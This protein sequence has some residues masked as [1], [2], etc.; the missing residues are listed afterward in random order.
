MFFNTDTNECSIGN[1]CGNGTCTNVIGGFECACDEGFEPGSM[2]TCEGMRNFTS[3]RQYF[4]SCATQVTSLI[5]LLVQTSMSVPRILY[6]VLF[7]VLMWWDRMSASAQQDMCC[8]KT[9]GCVKVQ[10]HDSLTQL[11]W[12]MVENKVS[13]RHRQVACGPYL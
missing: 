13:L 11:Y 10:L 6:F 3:F 9:R 5:V 1:P 7:V 8:V 12:K 2:M 4:Y